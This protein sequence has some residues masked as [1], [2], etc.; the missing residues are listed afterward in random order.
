MC[1]LS[2]VTCPTDKG[3]MLCLGLAVTAH[4]Y[5]QA[6]NICSFSNVDLPQC[7]CVPVLYF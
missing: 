6:A 1:V 2:M 4:C 5:C 3:H 7:V